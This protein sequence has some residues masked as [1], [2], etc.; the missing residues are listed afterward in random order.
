MDAWRV[1]Y[2]K[3]RMDRGI[4]GLVNLKMTDLAAERN[5]GNVDL[6]LQ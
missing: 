5:Q 1:R 4:D 3:G 6:N 2:I